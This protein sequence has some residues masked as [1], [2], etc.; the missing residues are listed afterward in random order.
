MIMPILERSNWAWLSINCCGLV[1]Y[2]LQGL[3]EA[4]GYEIG[5]GKDENQ[6]T[7]RYIEPCIDDFVGMQNIVYHRG[8]H[9]DETRKQYSCAIALPDD[10]PLTSTKL[11]YSPTSTVTAW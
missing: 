7:H 8:K 4:Q 9:D 2:C 6:Q 10:A 3:G 5:L 11:T 1:F